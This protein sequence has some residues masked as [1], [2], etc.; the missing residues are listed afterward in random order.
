MAAIPPAAPATSSVFRSAAERWN[1][2]ANRDPNAPPVMMM[3][4]SAPNGPP[5]P[6]E[7]A[8]DSGLSSATLA[9]IRLRPI[10]IA[11]MASGIPW[12]RIFSDPKRAIRPTTSPPAIGTRIA[13]QPS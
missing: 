3:G 9:L 5:L 11:S 8:E 4:P 12:P 2:W 7:T 6:I 1:A 13:H 10:R